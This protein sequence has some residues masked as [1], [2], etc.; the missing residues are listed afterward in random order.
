DSSGASA[1]P[2][3]YR[4]EQYDADLDAY[5]LRARYYQPGTGR[6]LTTEP[7]GGVPTKPM[8][9]HRYL[10]GNN[11]PLSFLDPSG[12]MSLTETLVTTGI[13]GNCSRSRTHSIYTACPLHRQTSP[14]SSSSK[15]KTKLT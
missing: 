8:T 13:I 12:K 9:Q 10:S 6:F 1:N 5:Y 4:G 7:F 14:L 15:R 11:D 3:L 2:Y